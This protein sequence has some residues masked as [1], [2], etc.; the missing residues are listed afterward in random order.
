MRTPLA[1]F[2]LLLIPSALTAQTAASNLIILQA[3]LNQN[4]P[5]GV[6]ARHSSQGAMEQI[7]NGGRPHQ[8]G[9]NI[10]LS[11]LNMERISQASITLRG[12][13]GPQVM[14]VAAQSPKDATETFTITPGDSPKASFHSVVYTGKLTGVRWVEVDEVT[15]ADGK[16]WHQTEGSVCRVAPNGYMLVNASR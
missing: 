7:N 10:A 11:S 6:E 4:C 15:Y 16:Q 13:A 12:L 5:V 2:A 14:L 3:P 8:L 1:V 9:F